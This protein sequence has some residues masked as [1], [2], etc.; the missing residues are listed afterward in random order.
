VLTADPDAEDP[1]IGWMPGDQLSPELLASLI[2]KGHDPQFYCR[3]HQDGDVMIYTWEQIINGPY[4]E[5]KE[6]LLAGVSGSVFIREP[7]DDHWRHIG[8]LKGPTPHPNCK[9]DWK[10]VETP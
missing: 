4:V 3:D 8:E 5:T 1:E 2:K 10:I 6:A 7:G 9:L